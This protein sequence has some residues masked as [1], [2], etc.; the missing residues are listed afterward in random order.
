MLGP[1][2][3]AR[4]SL[5]AAL[6][7]PPAMSS[8]ASRWTRSLPSQARPLKLGIGNQRPASA[9]GLPRIDEHEGVPHPSS[10]NDAVTILL[11]RSPSDV[12]P[13]DCGHRR[14]QSLRTVLGAARS[15]TLLKR[16]GNHARAPCVEQ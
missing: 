10:L 15:E 7:L 5:I 12:L 4:S 6:G 16:R 11:Q 14:R 8:T 2:G 3:F 1:H 9:Q 13:A